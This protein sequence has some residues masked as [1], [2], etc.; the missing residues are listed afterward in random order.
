MTE[1]LRIDTEG[2]V[3]TVTLLRP[4]MSP[5]FF[6]EVG[7]VF[8]GLATADVRAVVVRAE[9][10]AFSF[11]LD[12]V[13]AMGLMATFQARGGGNLAGPRT[14]LL[15]LIRRWQQSF[16][17]VAE[18]PVPVV[19]ALHGWCIGGGLD[20]AVACDVRVCSQDTKMSLRETRIGIVAD[21]GSLQRLPGIVGQ[22]RARELAFTGRDL[23]AEEAKAMGLV[24]EVLPDREATLQAAQQLARQIAANPP[25]TVRGVKE[26]M[27]F[28]EG[29][30][31]AEGLDYVAAWNSAFLASEDLGEAMAAF[32][33]KREPVFKGR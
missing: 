26:V 21:L 8:R 27:R 5:R 30:P 31:V 25:L 20:L 4:T 3:A 15:G 10:K 1:T 32:A 13:E 22:G 12:L 6:D 28:G 7:D 18:C 14:E 17:A 16:T 11:G 9:G 2:Q 24:S 19:A 23:G 33:A 29:R